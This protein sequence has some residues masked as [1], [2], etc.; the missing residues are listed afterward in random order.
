MTPCSKVSEEIPSSILYRNHSYRCENLKFHYK[1]V[2]GSEKGRGE[3]WT[4]FNLQI[5]I[6]LDVSF[7][8]TEFS[9]F[10]PARL[11]AIA[12]QKPVRFILAVMRTLKVFQFLGENCLSK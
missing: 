3:V 10:I 4:Y 12:F 7:V 8:Y 1:G 9:W 5:N 11:K 2:C 6:F